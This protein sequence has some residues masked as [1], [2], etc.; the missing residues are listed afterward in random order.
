MIKKEDAELFRTAVGAVT[1]LAENNRTTHTKP[2]C[3]AIVRTGSLTP[4]RVD[5]LYDNENDAPEN[6]LS[7]GLSNQLLRKLKRGN[8]SVQD[9]LDLHGYTV[10]AA[11]ILLQDF[12]LNATNEGLRCV[13]IIHGKGLNSPDGQAILRTLAR[14]WLVQHPQVLAFCS[15]APASGGSGAVIILLKNNTVPN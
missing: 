15:A 11:R 1:P 14:N 2:V 4:L 12:L 6:Y 13:L 5:S 9:S 8:F 10:S 3:H 7:N